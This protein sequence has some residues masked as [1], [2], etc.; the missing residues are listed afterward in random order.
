VTWLELKRREV[1]A[2]AA[3]LLL[4]VALSSSLQAGDNELIRE[5]NK[6][7]VATVEDGMRMILW[8]TE[9]AGAD[10]PFEEVAD[11]LQKAKLIKK[12]WAKKPDASLRKGQLAYMVVRV[13]KI[14][15]GLN[16]MLFGRNERYALRE[17]IFLGLLQRGTA[18]QYVSGLALLGT[19]GRAEVF[20]ERHPPGPH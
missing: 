10:E 2:A 3:A 5:L 14:R 9:G 4:L 16:M 11:R 1:A 19:I 13:C 7:P 18:G 15:G 8:L 20:V 12:S 6:K 17:C